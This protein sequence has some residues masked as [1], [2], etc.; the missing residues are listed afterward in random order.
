M[1]SFTFKIDE[2]AIEN[3]KL[4]LSRTPNGTQKAVSRAINRALNSMRTEATKGVRQHYYVQAKSVNE[5]F[6]IN[7]ASQN[8]LSGSLISR[9]KRLRVDKFRVKP[10]RDT[11]GKNRTAVKIEIKKGST[12]IAEKGFVHKST[13]FQR[14]G[15]KRLPIKVV[16]G[17]SVPQMLQNANVKDNVEK[18]GLNTFN[19]RI[20]HEVKALLKGFSK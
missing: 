4:L 14:I 9:G 8:N 20:N 17:A 2:K 12:F 13:V 7:R 5:T 19:K 15:P 10:N 16:L 11:T 6:K 3:A 18:A 1:S